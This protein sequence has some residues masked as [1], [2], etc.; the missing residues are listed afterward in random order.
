MFT[1]CLHPE[2]DNKNSGRLYLTYRSAVAPFRRQTAMPPE[3]CTRAG[4]LPSCSS[5]DRRSQEAQVGFEPR[6]FFVSR[7]SLRVPATLMIYSNP[8]WTVSEKH[9]HLRIMPTETCGGLC[10]AHSVVEYHKREIAP[11]SFERSSS[12]SGVII[13]VSPHQREALDSSFTLI[14][15][16]V[17]LPDWEVLTS[18]SID[19]TTRAITGSSSNDE[20]GTPITSLKREHVQT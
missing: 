12:C 8:N 11:L 3:G 9:T 20:S 19:R 14:R 7:R 10:A 6:I 4:L 18:G 2:E 15:A 17:T 1:A 16:L 13:P 5:L